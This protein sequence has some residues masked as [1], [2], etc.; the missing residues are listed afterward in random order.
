MCPVMLTCN[1][2]RTVIHRPLPLEAGG[3]GR[4]LRPETVVAAALAFFK[5]NGFLYTLRPDRLGIHAV[6]DFLFASRKGFCEHFATAFTVLMRAAGVPTRIVGGYQGGRWNALGDFLT[7][8]QSDAHVWCEV[9]QGGQGWVR[10]D[11]TF[12]V[13]PDRIDAGIERALA[14]EA[15]LWFLGRSRGDLLSRLDRNRASDLGGR[16]YP[17]EHVV[18]GLFRGRPDRAFETNRHFRGTAKCLA[19]VYGVAAVVCRRGDPAGQHSEKR[20]PE[21]A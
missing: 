5:E 17:V 9:W 1:C 6:D 12:A 16:K 15:L 2:H 14:G 19:A 13:A 7:V 20:D 4:M 8:R 3:P 11:P 18:H 10:V 21:T